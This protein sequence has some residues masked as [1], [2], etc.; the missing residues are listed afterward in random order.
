[1]ISVIDTKTHLDEQRTRKTE[2][3]HDNSGAEARFV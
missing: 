2:R 3:E 1:M